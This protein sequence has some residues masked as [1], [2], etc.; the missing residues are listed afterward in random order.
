MSISSK[1]RSISLSFS[2]RLLS[3]AGADLEAGAQGGGVLRLATGRPG[4]VPAHPGDLAD[5]LPEQVRDPGGGRFRLRRARGVGQIPGR[6]RAGDRLDGC[7][8]GRAAGLYLA[9]GRAGRWI[10]LEKL[11]KAGKSPPNEF[12]AAT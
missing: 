1:S 12:G 4:E 8:G 6:D 7:Q 11:D 9:W 10:K 5:P 2:K 3:L